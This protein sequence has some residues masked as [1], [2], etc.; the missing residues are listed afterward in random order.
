M[1]SGRIAPHLA[2]RG[3]AGVVVRQLTS[4]PDTRGSFTEAF[5][6][7]WA[8][9][10]DPVQ[11]NVVKSDTGAMRGVH[12]HLRHT[13]LLVVTA[14]HVTIGLHDLRTGSPT[15]RKSSTFEVNGDDMC[16][17][18]VPPGVAHG[19]LFHE[20]TITIYAVSRYWDLDDELA[21][22]WADPAL[23][24]EWPFPPTSVSERDATAGTVSDLLEQ[25]ALYQ[26]IWRSDQQLGFG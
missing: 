7:E 4:N 20:P 26:A 25:L 12:L 17:V 9:N 5:R 13:D 18:L 14:G 2:T 1:T 8:L 22:H 21:V 11:W 19:F 10:I 16:A 23:D 24:I 6:R 15:A 3:L